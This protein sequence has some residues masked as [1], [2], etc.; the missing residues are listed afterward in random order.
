M[1]GQIFTCANT[2][3]I[4]SR[5]DS[6]DEERREEIG[7]ERNGSEIPLQ[8]KRTVQFAPPRL[9]AS[10]DSPI[11]ADSKIPTFGTHR[12]ATIPFYCSGHHMHSNNYAGTLLVLTTPWTLKV[13]RCWLHRRRSPYM[14]SHEHFRFLWPFETTIRKSVIGTRNI[15]FNRYSSGFLAIHVF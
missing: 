8:T 1:R 14:V 4:G 9:A 11:K 10:P 3:K 2:E 12:A 15:E 6:Q 13:D 7:R 5:R